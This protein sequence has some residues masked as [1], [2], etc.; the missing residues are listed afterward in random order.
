MFH[1]GKGE[2]ESSNYCFKAKSKKVAHERLRDI[3]ET[4]NLNMIWG[5]WYPYQ[6]ILLFCGELKKPDMMLEVSGSS[7]RRMGL[8]MRSEL[9]QIGK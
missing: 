9:V 2:R 3:P 4:I 7:G 6:W 1:K 8:K 5:M